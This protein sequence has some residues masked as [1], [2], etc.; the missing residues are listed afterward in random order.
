MI[1][2]LKTSL[3]PLLAFSCPS[4]EILPSPE[5]AS[6]TTYFITGFEGSPGS[7]VALEKAHMGK[8][9]RFGAGPGEPF[10][11]LQYMSDPV[12]LYRDMGASYPDTKNLL[13]KDMLKVRSGVF[14]LN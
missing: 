4:L 2:Q 3:L 13:S 12:Y 11:G 1:F 14:V 7:Q 6:S 10:C 8:V 9:R 5:A